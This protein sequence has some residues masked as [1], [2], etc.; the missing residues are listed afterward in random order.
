MERGQSGGVESGGGQ[1][2]RSREKRGRKGGRAGGNY[3]CTNV[4]QAEIEIVL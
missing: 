3:A 2:W 1:E 4:Q